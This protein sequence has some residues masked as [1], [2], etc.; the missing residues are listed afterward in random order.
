[1]HPGAERTNDSGRTLRSLGR[2]SALLTL[3]S[4]ASKV[5]GWNAQAM[6]DLDAD[7]LLT[8]VTIH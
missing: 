6:R 1:M 4:S 8:H 5:A 7:A 2:G 3:H